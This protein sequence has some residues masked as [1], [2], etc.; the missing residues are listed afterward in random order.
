[1]AAKIETKAQARKEDDRIEKLIEE[2]RAKMRGTRNFD[3]RFT[4]AR[5]R[6][7]QSALRQKWGI[8]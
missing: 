7:R 1:M 3:P 6:G 8:N 4:I 2:Q 5:L